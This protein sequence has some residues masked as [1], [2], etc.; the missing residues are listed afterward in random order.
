MQRTCKRSGAESANGVSIGL[1]GR[2]DIPPEE[3]AKGTTHFTSLDIDEELLEV[4]IGE[5]GSIRYTLEI[6]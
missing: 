6:P 2:P 5:A 1:V 3:R 4:G